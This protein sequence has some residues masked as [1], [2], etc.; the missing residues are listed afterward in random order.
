MNPSNTYW[1]KTQRLT[2][3]LLLIW[4]VV[5]FALSW[6]APWLNQWHFLG[7]PLGFYMAAQ[8]SLFIYLLLIW[9]YNRRMRQLDAE[10]GIVDE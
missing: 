5:T 2:L 6:F 8:G 3:L 10:F 4:V 7:F 9:I 1:K